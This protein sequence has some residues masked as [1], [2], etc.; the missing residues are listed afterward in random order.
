MYE[1]QFKGKMIGEPCQGTDLRQFRWTD[2][3]AKLAASREHRD[4]C[5]TP[6]A[7]FNAF[8]EVRR[9]VYPEGKRAVNHT[10]LSDGKDT[11]VGR[12]DAAGTAVQGDR[13]KE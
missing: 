10:D 7:G 13:E 8:A 4:D 1:G 2:L 6:E 3:V 9:E 11:G 5:A 12:A